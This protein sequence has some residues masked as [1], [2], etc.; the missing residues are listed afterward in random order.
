MSL[1]LGVGVG[2]PSQHTHTDGGA[3]QP[4]P[5]ARLN[6]RLAVTQRWQLWA[7]SHKLCLLK[8]LFGQQPPPHTH[9]HPHPQITQTHMCTHT[10]T[11]HQFLLFFAPHAVPMVGVSCPTLHVPVNQNCP[12]D[13]RLLLK[14][15]FA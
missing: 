8:G 12:K 4:C 6:V 9:A 10:N 7:V 2:A 13:S 5:S 3:V 14:R 11:P 15:A 1:G